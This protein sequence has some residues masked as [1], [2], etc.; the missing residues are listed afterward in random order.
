MLDVNEAYCQMTGYSRE[1]L[2]AM[3]ITDLEAVE[4][5]EEM[6][7]HIERIIK[8]GSDRFETLHRAKDGRFID[9][10]VSVT[11]LPFDGGHFIC[12]LRDITVRK[13]M[14]RQAGRLERMAAMGQLLGGIAHELRNPLFVLTG[15]LQ[16]LREKLTHREYGAL[17]TDLEKIEAAGQRMTAIARRFL[18]FARPHQP[19]LARCSVTAV[20]EDTVAFLGNELTKNHIQVAT[21]LAPDLP[22]ILGDPRQLQEAFFNLALNAMQAMVTVHGHGTLTVTTAFVPAGHPSPGEGGGW[23]EVRIQD[24]GPGIAPEHRSKVFEPFFTTKP[25]GQGTG[26]GLWIVR[27]TLMTMKGSI[28]YETEVGQGTTFIVRLPVLSENITGSPSGPNAGQEAHHDPDRRAG[29]STG[30]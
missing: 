2:L 18:A 6:A 17:E 15:H 22:P 4:R 21:R 26:L 29:E 9:L 7:R 28:T 19:V 10:D 24:D 30:A 13:A 14:E 3:R 12:F 16:L 27:S 8:A 25:S 1:E 20:V 23:V 11:H 5:R